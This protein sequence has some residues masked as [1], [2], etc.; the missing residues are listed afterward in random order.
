MKLKHSLYSLTLFSLL[1]LPLQA[2]EPAD[3]GLVINE[4][5]VSNLDMYLDNANCYGSWIELYN[6]TSASI[7]IRNMYLTDGLNE[8]RL[9][10]SHGTVPAG[11]FKTLWF[12]HYQTDGSYGTNSKLQIPFKLE[13]EGGTISL[14]NTDKSPVCSVTYPEAVPRCSWARKTDGGEEW[15]VTGEPTPD[16]SNAPSSFASYRLQAPRVNTDSRVFSE[17]FVIR[18]TYPTTATLRY[19]TDGST[20]TLDNGE[21][22][23][24]GRFE[25]SST[26]ILR[27]RLFRSGSLPSPVVTRSY[28]YQNHGYYL[29]VLSVVSDPMHFFDDKIGVFVRGSNGVSGNGQSSACNWNMDWER[30]VNME[31]LVPVKKTTDDGQQATD[32]LEQTEDGC[33]KY[34]PILNQE[35][36]L[37]ICGGWTR[38]YGGGWGD[39]RYWEARSSFRLKTDQRYEGVKVID[40]PVFPMKP[41]N[42]YRC[43]Q[44]RNGGNDTNHRIK[45]AAIQVMVLRSGFYVDCQDYQPAHVF[46]NGEYF[47]MLN[48]RE[49]NNKHFAYSNYGID[50][51]DMDQFDL[52]NAKYNQK[53]G[54][55]VAWNQLKSL[56]KRLAQYDLEET[57]Q[58]ICELLDIDE[59]INYM[60]L[61]CFI[62]SSDWIT[63][64]NNVKGFRSRTDGKF[65]FVLFDLDSAFAITNMLNQVLNTSAGADVDDLFRSLMKYDPI[66]RQFMDAFCIVNGSVFEPTRCEEIVREIYNNTNYALSFERNSSSLGLI[67]TIRSAH[68]DSER[69][70]Y[71]SNNFHPQFSLNANLSSNIPEARLS[72]NGQEIPTGKFEGPLYSYKQLPV[73]IT[74]KAPAGYAFEGW[75]SES[76][77]SSVSALI[78]EGSEWMYYDQGSMDGFDWKDISFD[79][80][81]NG[82]KT[83]TAPF[84]F[85]RGEGYFM[86][87]NSV[88]KLDQGASG[89]KRST[90][91]FRKNFHLDFPLSNDDILTFTYQIDDGVMLYVNGHEVGG[92]YI[93]SGSTYSDYTIG[94][95]YEENNPRIDQFIIP[96]EFLVVGENQIAVEAKNCS[97]SSTDMW[98]EGSLSL[99]SKQRNYVS[100][101]EELDLQEA[102]TNDTTIT[103]KAIYVPITEE[104]QRWAEGA[105]P[106]RIN[107][108]SAGNDIYISDYGKKSDWVEL[109]NTTDHDISLKGIYLSD[110]SNKPQKFQMQ[111][112]VVPAHGTCVI[113]C[114]NNEAINQLHAPFKLSNADGADITIQAEDGSWA[115][116]LE[117]LEQGKWQTYGRYPDGGNMATILN[118]P[119]ID[120]SNKLGMSDFVALSDE[121]WLGKDRTITL[122]LAEGWNWTSHNLNV[123]VDKSRFT[124]NALNLQGEDDYLA[125]SEEEGW[126]GTLQALKD[127]KG[128][129]ICM[130][131]DATVTLRGP[132]YD[133]SWPV[134]LHSGWNWIGCPLFNSTTLE[135]ALANYVPSEGDK[136]V[137]LDMFATYEEGEWRGSLKVLQPGQSYLFYTSA[138]QEFCWNSLSPMKSRSKRY[139]PAQKAGASSED[140]EIVNS[141]WLNG[142]WLHSYPDVMTMVATV[143]ADEGISLDQP[144]YVG[145]FCGEECRGVGILEDGLLY[146]NIHGEGEARI[147]FRLLDAFGEVY[148]SLGYVNFQDCRQLGTVQKPFP[149]WFASQDVIDEIKPALASSGKIK[150]V[151]YF[152]LSGQRID[153][154]QLSSGVCIR[155]EIFEDGSVK[156]S[157]VYE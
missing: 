53:M 93:N 78:P 102:F 149:L 133:V 109:Y 96:H 1:I 124:E 134:T 65:H 83:G 50:F 73:L 153:K 2:Q 70:N 125:Y 132:I 66:R 101:N 69:M 110:N 148:N 13:C 14:L 27:L 57:Y 32:E 86:Q 63:N 99:Q 37:E 29:P 34:S 77:E 128:Y 129:K 49:S 104:R 142:K 67:S 123:R 8:Y 94:G 121:D 47:G 59:Y 71:M 56:A 21:T 28:I 76:S 127:A 61:E 150:A 19:T 10:S 3:L 41:Y 48:I 16:A 126:Q 51:D 137:G 105:S 23:S 143:D 40:Y 103:L 54:D 156:V 88:T 39:D 36:D 62:G 138:E 20:P 12:D 146:M 5:Q 64:T 9:T 113:W 33:T 46:L 42:K 89:S 140:E 100:M 31:Y 120:K 136:L 92:Y 82:W 122:E 141:K 117:Y 55:N 145:A 75:L 68:N 15:G 74:A 6:P 7:S 144:Y 81:A 135:A 79:E 91:Y 107:E 30:P 44:V 155:R 97:K 25:I 108:V 17:P 80:A 106:L 112:G 85:A 95:H 114:D 90:Y 24:N 130:A 111:E 38:A 119:T 118:Q 116:C 18:V 157:K 115:D 4:V 151:Q 26:T 87:D 139:A 11:G 84:G 147:Q 72:L 43:W 60:A 45:D 131:K 152:N 35:M 154:S 22:S 58:Q 98:F 52:S